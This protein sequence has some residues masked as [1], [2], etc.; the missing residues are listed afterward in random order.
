MGPGVLPAGSAWVGMRGLAQAGV[1]GYGPWLV[2]RGF[3]PEFFQSTR[4]AIR[5]E[6]HTHPDSPRCTQG[7]R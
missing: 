2:L 6:G 3:P 7:L 4:D 1:P 5:W